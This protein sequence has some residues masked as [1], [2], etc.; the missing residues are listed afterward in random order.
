MHFLL[1]QVVTEAG[2][3]L[4]PAWVIAA[5][6]TV[7][8]TLLGTISYLYRGQ[9]GAL[10]ERIAWL[11]EEGQR[12]DERCDRLIDQVGRAANAAERSVSLVEK[13]QRTPR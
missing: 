6:G 2:F 13:Q 1:V 7:L 10:R 8:S 12:K 5:A 3:K 11:E 4:D 9:I